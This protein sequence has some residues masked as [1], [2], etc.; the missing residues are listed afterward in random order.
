MFNQ[1]LIL[2]HDFE[3]FKGTILYQEWEKTN[4]CLK[5]KKDKRFNENY[6]YIDSKKQVFSICTIKELILKGF[7]LIIMN[8]SE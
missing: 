8:E 6:C 5:L 1:E 2:N 4:G 7:P 3:Q